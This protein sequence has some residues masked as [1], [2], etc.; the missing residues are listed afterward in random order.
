[1]KDNFENFTALSSAEL[2]ETSGGGFAYD[3]GRILRFLAI[4]STIIPGPSYAIADWQINA[5]NNE[6]Q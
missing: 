5:L 3:V 4:S 1:M 2:R 6:Y